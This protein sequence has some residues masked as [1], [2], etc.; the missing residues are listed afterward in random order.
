MVFSHIGLECVRMDVY[1]LVANS[2]DRVFRP[3]ES[4]Y[5]GIYSRDRPLS[6]PSGAR[7]CVMQPS[8]HMTALNLADMKDY[9]TNECIDGKARLQIYSEMLYDA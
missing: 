9:V 2:G 8:I 7:E 6:V 3:P 4:F 1:E 5:H